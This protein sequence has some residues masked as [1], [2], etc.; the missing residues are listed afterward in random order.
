MR[1]E[2]SQGVVLIL[3][4]PCSNGGVFTFYEMNAGAGLVVTH[5]VQ[6]EAY[7]VRYATVFGADGEVAKGLNWTT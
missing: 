4:D 2:A 7:V 1:N 3:F 5:I 6:F